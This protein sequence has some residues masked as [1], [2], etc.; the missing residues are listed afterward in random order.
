MKAADGD[1]FVAKTVEG[2][3]MTFKIISEEEKTVQVGNGTKNTPAIADSIA[4][5]LSI[6]SS[7][8]WN[9]N[10]YSVVTI[11]NYAFYNCASLTEVIIPEL[12]SSIGTYAFSGCKSLTSVNI[13][14]GITSISNYSF[15][16]CTSLALVDLPSTLESIGNNAFYGSGLTTI[17]I[18]KGVTS[19]GTSA[20]QKCTSLS[21]AVLPE[22]L[23][24]INENAFRGCSKLVKVIARMNPPIAFGSN[25]F[26]GISSLC[27]L[28]VPEDTKDA[29]IE[30]GWTTDIFKGGLVYGDEALI[31]GD[32]FTMEN[33][34]GITITY[35]VTDVENNYVQV[36][37]GTKNT[38]SIDAAS[39]GTLRIPSSVEVYGS[40]YQVNALSSY[41]FYGCS[42]ITEVVVPEA[43]S[44][45]GSYAFY[46]CES[47]TAI[48]I[49]GG[50]TAIS[51]N[52]FQGCSNLVT[53]DLPKSLVTIGNNAF[54]GSGIT[55]IDIPEGVTSIGTGTFQQC[56]SLI[57]V[58]LP[59]SLC[60]LGDNAFRNSSKISKVIARM[61]EPFVFG[62]TPFHGIASSCGLHVPEGTK[63]AYI[64]AGWTTDIF[65]GGVVYGDE[66]LVIG[67][68]FTKKNSDGV[69]ITYK[70]T[71]VDNN[72]VQVGIGAKNTPAVDVATSGIVVI[73]DSVECNGVN[74]AVATIGSYAFQ[75]CGELTSVAIPQ[76]VTYI[77]AYAFDACGKIS[78]VAIPESVTGLGAYAFQSTSLTS[79]VIPNG[80]TSIPASAFRS[81]SALA[82][83]TLPVSLTAIGDNAFRQC[84]VLETIELPATLENVG[85]EAFRGSGLQEIYARMSS[86]FTISGDE[87]KGLPET[88]GLHVPD[89]TKEAY[90]AAGWTKDVFK[91]GIVYGDDTPTGG[92]Q[93]KVTTVEGVELL[94]AILD[95]DEKTV[96]VGTGTYPN[97]TC[98]P[99]T[100]GT[101]T[102]PGMVE[103]NGEQWIV[104]HISS[105]AFAEYTG[106]T[107]VN[108]PETVTDIYMYSF[109]GCTALKDVVMPE[110]VTALGYAVF[111]NCTSL[112]ELTLP[113]TMNYLGDYAIGNC[114][115][116][117]NL[118]VLNPVAYEFKENTF[119]GLNAKCVLHVP[120]GTIDAYH[121]AGWTEGEG[122]IF[123]KIVEGDDV[124]AEGTEFKVI[125][126]EGVELTL[127]I[128]SMD[129]LTCQVGSGEKNDPCVAAETR[130]SVTVPATAEY[131][132]QVFTV[133]AIGDRAFRYTKVD[134]V[135]VPE[136]VGTLIQY[137]FANCENLSYVSL[138]DSINSLGMAAFYK[139]PNLKE[140]ELPDSL[141]E[142]GGY[143]FSGSGLETVTL[144]AGVKTITRNAFSAC[145]NLKW[146][147]AEMQE[148]VAFGQSAFDGI[149]PECVLIVPEGTKEAYI[150]AGWN[151]TV[152]GGLVYESEPEYRHDVNKDGSVDINDV[153]AVINH[154]AGAT[155]YPK[156]DT[157]RDEHTD[158]NDVVSI[159]NFM[160]G[161]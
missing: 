73:P 47:L 105:Y 81:C 14:A 150:E 61:S 153:V 20:F 1:T 106:I 119:Y 12:I 145:P 142:I 65:K 45:I 160:A 62:T 24:T 128:T 88:C 127:M 22:S 15:Y 23:Q 10:T 125:T 123:F 44:L 152:F 30:A 50:V 49:P 29:Y 56:K 74:Y 48:N 8:E 80:I 85:T 114:T 90:I 140:I 26:Y 111:Y 147:V 116:L 137:A 97:T 59:S 109:Y 158:I 92:Y 16:N 53:I 7:V 96:Q 151:Q 86:P 75:N 17:D 28:H 25:A 76:T 6:P 89:G 112:K 70:V 117:K 60:S 126:V 43:V 135:Y 155:L 115:A 99:N 149:D 36:G 55:M 78:E 98:D 159:I 9:D 103:L 52:C 132:G 84:A 33:Q 77:G 71:D 101:I 34:D 3:D 5:D 87:F 35:K 42:A 102:I 13:P 66:T 124:P 154:M 110:G 161:R 131:N 91:G 138:P 82:S 46:G 148:P 108:V 93:F 68:T 118:Y 11:G 39:A 67:D 134:S 156:S 113:A 27:G 157:N 18:P 120:E 122:G 121:E 54:Y 107:A 19:V 139:C 144:P 136:T 32:T 2:I 63:E 40:T 95:V 41:A 79:I 146:V 94:M 31:L 129:P 21:Q 130:G 58:I 133:T 143:A 37:T 51:N 64:E 72:Y 100:T 38:P 141:E 57:E 4:G 104:K 69:A 83:V